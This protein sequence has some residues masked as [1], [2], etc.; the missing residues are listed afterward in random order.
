MISQPNRIRDLKRRRQRQAN[1][2]RGYP[3]KKR[4]VY[5]QARAELCVESDYWGE[6]PFFD[7]LEF[8]RMFSCSIHIAKKCVEVCIKNRPDVFYDQLSG[9]KK[10]KAHVKVLAVLKTL[11]FGVSFN[12]FTDYFQLDEGT[13]RRAFHA[14]CDAISSDDELL[15]TFL[16]TMMSRDDAEKVVAKHKDIHGVDGLAYSIDCCHIVWKNCP[17]LWKGTFEGKEKVPTIVLEAGAD[18]D[19]FFWHVAFGFPGTQNDINIWDRSPLHTLL[20]DGTWATQVDPVEP[21]CI[22]GQKFERLFFLV[23]GIYPELARFVK[24]MSVPTNDRNKKYAKWQEAS[25][26]DVERSF[27]VLQSK[28][29][30]LTRPIELW[31]LDEIRKAVLSCIIIHNMM[32]RYRQD[33]TNPTREDYLHYAI[34]ETVRGKLRASLKVDKEKEDVLREFGLLGGVESPNDTIIPAR[35]RTANERRREEQLLAKRGRLLE[36]RLDIQRIVNLRDRSEHFRLREAI[37]D[38]LFAP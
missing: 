1:R 30:W 19:L 15:S 4:R 22:G 9:K 17:T 13:V 14:F 11:R 2:A 38:E 8:Q 34:N 28:F 5:N 26:K 27:G 23:D 12:A 32:V 37:T 36:E 10:I 24:T 31:K 33:L 7:D 6:E 16:P 20:V 18:Y 25:R 3:E 29:R 21:F 35:D